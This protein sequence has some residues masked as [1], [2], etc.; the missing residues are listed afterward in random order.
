MADN[1]INVFNTEGPLVFLKM[2]KKN[3]LISVPTRIT[4]HSQTAIDH[5][6]VS[7]PCK[8]L[9]SGVIVY[10]ISDHF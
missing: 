6:V 1:N 5:I 7:D 10:G 3:Q 2:R 9:Q 8:I 4:Q